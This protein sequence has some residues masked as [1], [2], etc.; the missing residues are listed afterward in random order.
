MVTYSTSKSSKNYGRWALIMFAVVA[1]IIGIIVR[2]NG[3]GTWPFSSDEY[4]FAKS[5]ENVLRFGLPAYECGGYYTRGV[6]LQY[7]AAG[8]QLSGLSAELAPRAVA[9]TTS[10]LALPAVFLLGRRLY[11]NTTGLLVLALIAIS[12]WEVEIARFGR[13]YAPFQTVFLWYLV[14]FVRYTVDKQQHA[15]WGI[16]ALSIVGVLVWEGGVLLAVAN[17]L[18]PFLNHTQGRLNIAQC[19]YLGWMALLLFPIYWFAT[20]EFRYL[21]DISP[22]PPNYDSLVAAASPD[23]SASVQPIWMTLP[24]HPLWFVGA[25]PLFAAAGFSLPWIM[26]F[27]DR[28]M[29]AA[30]LLVVL[31]AALLHQFSV[32]IATL[33]LLLLFRLMQWRELLC[34]PALGFVIAILA[35]AVFWTT[36]GLAT[37]TWRGDQASGLGGVTIALGY[38]FFGFP[39]F[40]EVIARPWARAVPVL[41]ISVLLLTTVA[42]IRIILQN[43]AMSSAKLST[44]RVLLIIA[45]VLVLLSS[46]SDAPRT[47]T[48]YSFFLYPLLLIF[49]VGTLTHAVEFIVRRKRIA[50]T[51]GVAVVLGWYALTEDLQPNHLRNIDTAEI[52]FRLNMSSGKRTH[53]IGRTD[54]RA[55]TDWLAAHADPSTDL[56]ISGNGVTGLDFYYPHFD[57]VYVDPRDQRLAA[58]ACRQGTVERWTNL[59]LVYSMSTLQSRIAASPRSYMVIDGRRL[60]LIWPDVEHLRPTVVWENEYGFEVIIRF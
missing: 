29:L 10:L 18:P 53:Y 47:T 52:N 27:R 9:A 7:L 17:F 12:V 4:Y 5:V 59:P 39:D 57:F 11:G 44:E 49:A 60:N 30:G 38:Q 21:G 46:A 13:M 33:T 56:I 22:L 40:L 28:W 36:V 41:G 8:L 6:L 43:D 15:V 35:A 3:L 14:Y 31:A 51:L 58:W 19:R 34:R 55:V 20:H 42:A 50:G 16:I 1:V 24:G 25:L 37:H 48:R 45:I 23:A 32:V 26:Q 54:R 2:F